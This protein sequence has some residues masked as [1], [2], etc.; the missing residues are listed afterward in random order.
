MTARTPAHRRAAAHVAILSRWRDPD[1]PELL[2]A[3]RVLAF[4]RAE[5]RLGEATDALT[6][7]GAPPHQFDERPV[8]AWVGPCQPGETREEY[9]ARIVRSAA[10]PNPEQ[11]AHLAALLGPLGV[12]KGQRDAAPPAARRIPRGVSTGPVGAPVGGHHACT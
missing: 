3:R 6:E 9:V 10:L 1:D 12:A 7:A 5:A 8:T 2:Q 4:T 11:F